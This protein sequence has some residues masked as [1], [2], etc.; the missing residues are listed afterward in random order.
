[1]ATA[2]ANDG[3][4]PDVVGQIVLLRPEEIEVG[5]RLRD[6]DPL[7]AEALGGIMKAEGQ[8]TPIEV[9]RLPGRAKYTLV[10][11]AH[12]HAGATSKGIWLRAEVVTNDAA[13]RRLREV[14]E[15][16]HRRDLDPAT[17][18]SHIAELVTL[19]KVRAG[20]DPDQDGRRASADARWSKQLKNDADDAN[21]T[22]TIAYGWADA[23][24]ADLGFS[25][26]AIER[27]LYLHRRLPPSLIER[28]RNARHPILRNA[29][30][31]RA[32]AKLG[33]DALQRRVVEALIGGQAKNV[34][35]AVIAIGASNKRAEDPED[36][37]FRTVIGALARMARTE[38]LALVQ[39]P[40]F[41]DLLPAEARDLLTSIR[42]DEA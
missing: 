28:L 26:S 19:H 41:Q 23:V 38:R 6:I 27:D 37:R 12:R 39:S 11:G 14:S 35:G 13:E 9:C 33:T 32:L 18:A 30:Q 24:A 22:M 17:R 5:T 29:S 42:R 15:N 8:R 10:T 7:W 36:K 16:L 3:A 4:A 20:V 31:L 25:R 40:T 34:A 21:V 2:A 1:M